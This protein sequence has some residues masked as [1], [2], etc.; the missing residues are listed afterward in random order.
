MRLACFPLD[1]SAN[2]EMFARLAAVADSAGPPRSSDDTRKSPARRWGYALAAGL[3]C[4]AV[5]GIWFFGR[6]SHEATHIATAAHELRSA[7]LPD[8][9]MVTLNSRTEVKTAFSAG[10]RRVRMSA[11]EA[12]FDV[13]KDPPPFIHR[14]C[15]QQRDPRRGHPVQCPPGERL[16]LYR[17]LH[18]GN[19][20][21]PIVAARQ[22][23]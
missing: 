18:L 14:P 20:P 7:T 3:A 1:L 16:F 15:W 10:E 13:T 5:S 11:G 17:R 6:E 23:P 22:T 19:Q 21:T 2:A 9:T 12:F 8:G 4:L